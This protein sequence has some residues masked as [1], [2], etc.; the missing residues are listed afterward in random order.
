MSVFEPLRKFI[1]PV[2]TTHNILR[3]W[4]IRKGPTIAPTDHYRQPNTGVGSWKGGPLSGKGR[5]RSVSS[6]GNLRIVTGVGPLILRTPATI[7][8]HSKL[9][10]YQGW[11]LVHYVVAISNGS[12]STRAPAGFL[13]W[14]RTSLI[15][16]TEVS[17]FAFPMRGWFHLL[18]SLSRHVQFLLMANMN[19]VIIYLIESGHLL[20]SNMMSCGY[21]RRMHN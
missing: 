6:L 4:S 21:A 9:F 16:A 14:N 10:T 13:R 15:E 19:A 3:Q 11:L 1:R 2:F 12:L 17:E 7:N 5:T 20:K 8:S 18:F